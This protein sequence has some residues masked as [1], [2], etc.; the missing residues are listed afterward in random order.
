M[1][2]I[3]TLLF[4]LV[5]SVGMMY[6]NVYS[7]NCGAEGD[8]SNLQWSF[9]TET[10]D[11]TITGGGDMKDFEWNS[12]AGQSDA[13]WFSYQ[14]YIKSLIFEDGVTSI[15]NEAFD[16][17]PTLETITLPATLTRIGDFAL[18]NCPLLTSISIPASV[19]TIGEGAFIE[20]V[21][22]QSF[23]VDEANVSYCSIDA[24]LFTKDQKTLIAF[25]PSK[26]GTYII[27]DGVTNIRDYAFCKCDALTSI[28]ISNSVTNIGNGAFYS[29]T[30]LTSVTLGGGVTGIGDY[31]FRDCYSLSSIEIP[32]SVTDIGQLAFYQC[33]G[34][35]SVTFGSGITNIGYGVFAYCIG[36]ISIEIPDNVTEIGKSAFVFCS[37]LTS[38]TIGKGVSSIGDYA[39]N[40]CNGLTSIEI[41]NSVTYIGENAFFGTLNIEYNGTADGAPWGAKYVNK[42]VDGWLAFSDASKTDLVGCS[43]AANGAISIPNSVTNIGDEAFSN[44]R[45]LT[46]IEIPNSVTSIGEAAFSTCTGLTS[47][48]IPNSVI[49]LGSGA[50]MSCTGL[51]SV[52]IPKSVT[53]IGTVLFQFCTGLTTIIVES[54]N[55]MYDSRNDCNAII[56]T[57]TNKLIAGCL[58]TV[59]PNSVAAIG[60]YAFRGCSGLTTIEI[61]NS[62][63]SIEYCAFEY[64][65]G[66]TA[67]EIP[68]SVQ[69]IQWMTFY[70]CSALTSVTIPASVAYIHDN[71]FSQCT[72]LASITCE[73]IN[74]PVCDDNVFSDVDKSIPL[75]VPEGSVTDYK[76]ASQWQDFTNIQ[77]IK[78]TDME[79]INPQSSKTRKIIYNGHLFILRNGEIFNAQGARVE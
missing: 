8:G 33:S 46:S 15:G 11:M 36:L 17:C 22:L 20:S 41:P 23:N 18:Q 73:A 42:Y 48:N 2:K 37:N 5:A 40:G 78:T 7:G 4:A 39:F 76:E 3:F 31:A 66:L 51:T 72:A 28:E 38:V 69:A 58:N 74:P 70:G 59:I 75:S 45:D 55:T 43:T 68:N 16:N 12:D 79:M 49:N 6:A 13:P 54:E 25:P 53:S 57:G 67:I 29:C 65:S 52:T 10:G 27:P 50:F 21:G 34:L 14:P 62:V 9:D 77:A 47:I 71:A 64:C 56:E 44:C 61:P 1:R 60:C 32:N 30:G 63:T 26:Q 35:T 19:T 24:V